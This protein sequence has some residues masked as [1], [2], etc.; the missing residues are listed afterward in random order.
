[1]HTRHQ[2]KEVRTESKNL[3]INSTGIARFFSSLATTVYLRGNDKL[4]LKIKFKHLSLL[5][6]I[7]SSDRVHESTS[8]SKKQHEY[9]IHRH[10]SLVEDCF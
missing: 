9:E 3:L 10:L 7:S 4:Q 2:S 8:H 5:E 6:T 1:M